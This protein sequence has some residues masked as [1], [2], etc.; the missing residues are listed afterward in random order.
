MHFNGRNSILRKR[1]IFLTRWTLVV[2][3]YKKIRKRICSTISLAKQFSVSGVNNQYDW[4]RTISIPTLI[5]PLKIADLKGPK[6][7]SMF[8][9]NAIRLFHEIILNDTSVIREILS[10]KLMLIYIIDAWLRRPSGCLLSSCV[11][12]WRHPLF[13]SVTRLTAHGQHNFDLFPSRIVK[14]VSF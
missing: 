10:V 13:T 7:V 5:K 3:K 6:M 11:G 14:R 2:V 8:F 4:V 1:T 12:P 9:I